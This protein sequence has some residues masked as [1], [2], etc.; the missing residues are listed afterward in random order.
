MTLADLIAQ[1]RIEMSDADPKYLCNDEA[2]T[3]FFNEAENEACIRARLIR[4]KANEDI[5]QINVLEG[6]S[7]Y[8]LDPRIVEIVYGSMFY[9]GQLGLPYILAKTTSDVLDQ[10]RPYWRAQHYRPTALIHYDSSIEFDCIPDTDYTVNLEVYRLP[11]LPMAFL[12]EIHPTPAVAHESPEINSIH[13]RHLV[14]WAKH[15]TYAIRDVELNNLNLSEKY[16]AEFEDVFGKRPDAK[17]RRGANAN[18]PHHNLV[19]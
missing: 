9:A 13:H 11:L 4:E 14:K 6:V 2:V 8:P 18:R 15:R 10:F 12:P 5:C 3:L 7:T 17:Y 19:W 1:Y 16:L